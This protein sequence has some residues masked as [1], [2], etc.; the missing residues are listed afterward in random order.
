[1]RLCVDQHD[2]PGEGRSA[3]RNLA[4]DHQRSAAAAGRARVD[5]G[6]GARRA[7]PYGSRNAGLGEGPSRFARGGRQA[8]RG[9]GAFDM[10]PSAKR[11]YRT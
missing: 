5:D 10:S 11:R 1:M 4:S 6:A 2:W 8:D 3:D 9:E 7:A